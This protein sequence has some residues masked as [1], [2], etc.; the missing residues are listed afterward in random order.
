MRNPLRA[1]NLTDEEE[2][3]LRSVSLS[4]AQPVVGAILIN[5]TKTINAITSKMA[6]IAKLHGRNETQV[7]RFI[8][9]NDNL[10]P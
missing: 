1:R 2:R 3:R 4:K 8:T 6:S 9:H 5:D 10:S 7:I